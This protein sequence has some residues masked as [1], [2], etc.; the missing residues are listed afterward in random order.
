[1]S[2]EIHFVTVQSVKEIKKE[3]L[4]TLQLERNQ[5]TFGYRR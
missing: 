1:M 3:T 5:N 2:R 4:V